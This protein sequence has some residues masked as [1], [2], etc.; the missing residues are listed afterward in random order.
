[1][2]RTVFLLDI[3]AKAVVG[4]DTVDGAKVAV[5]DE[6]AD[7]DAEG[8]ETGPDGFHEEEVLRFSLFD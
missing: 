7:L 6:F 2:S 5:F 4:D 8:K 3:V 1:M